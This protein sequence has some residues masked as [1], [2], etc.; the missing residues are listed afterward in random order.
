MI[1]AL[2]VSTIAKFPW[3]GRQHKCLADGK[4]SCLSSEFNDSS[5]RTFPPLLN[6]PGLADGT[7][8]LLMES[9]VVF[10]LSLMIVH[11]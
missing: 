10:L 9:S 6:S 1:Q 11:I 8:V 4:L 2:N 7:N 3:I 5:I